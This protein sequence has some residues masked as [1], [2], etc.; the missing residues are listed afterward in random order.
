MSEVGAVSPEAAEISTSAP[1]AKLEADADGVDVS[2][3]AV[4][5]TV[6]GQDGLGGLDTETSD[7]SVGEKREDFPG[8]E[9]EEGPE[10]M[11]SLRDHVGRQ[12]ARALVKIKGT[13][14]NKE[15][16]NT[17][18]LE[19]SANSAIE[20][21]TSD[22]KATLEALGGV[23]DY[24]ADVPGE[25]AEVSEIYDDIHGNTLVDV[26][27]ETY[28]LAELD[29]EYVTADDA[30]KAQI[31]EIKSNGTYR[32]NFSPKNSEKDQAAG[33]SEA[34]GEKAPLTAEELTSEVK[35][36]VSAIENKLKDKSLSEEKKAQLQEQL[37]DLNASLKLGGEVG[38]T[39]RLGVINGIKEGMSPDSDEFS[40]L[41][42][43]VS[44]G[45]EMKEAHLGLLREEFVRL[46][47]SPTQTEV[48]MSKISEGRVGEFLQDIRG[49]AS[50]RLIKLV[51]GKDVKDSGEARKYVEDLLYDPTTMEKLKK[52]A[53]QI[54]L[55]ACL[56]IIGAGIAGEMS[57]S[58]ATGDK[59]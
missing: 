57:N 56:A 30:R 53:G 35:T 41:G 2:P 48:Y 39:A 26:R 45:E 21:N 50:P 58:I 8:L 43:I 47:L 32:F 37:N 40:R 23:K 29:N 20:S 27:G 44:R 14:D 10:D 31:D 12:R 1:A 36:Q 18:E 16:F 17:P 52:R 4:G 6:S 59:R 19:S 54:G 5:P 51:F 34:S 22:I 3:E 13:K 9:D 28:S 11:E 55:L 33:G 38:N 46:G 42:D 49:V 7:V 15:I 25:L 24:V